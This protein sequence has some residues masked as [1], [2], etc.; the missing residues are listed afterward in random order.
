MNTKT[1]DLETALADLLYKGYI[2]TQRISNDRINHNDNLKIPEGFNF[3]ALQSVSHE[4]IERLER[5]NPQNFAQIRN[6]PGMT[7]AA[8]STILVH[9]TSAKASSKL[10]IVQRGTCYF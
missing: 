3:R 9:L 2:E 8:V 10:S 7:P 4:M 6:I 5:A 1:A